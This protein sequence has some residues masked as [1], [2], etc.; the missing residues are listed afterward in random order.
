[1]GRALVEKDAWVRLGRGR[2]DTGG[3]S[4]PMP[5]LLAPWARARHQRQ[6][7]RGAVARSYLGFLIDAEHH[8]SVRW[9]QG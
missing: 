5:R 8:C 3:S 1:M 9:V 6:D 7:R 4:R 2:S